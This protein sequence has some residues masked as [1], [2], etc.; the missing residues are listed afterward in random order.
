MTRRELWLWAAI[1]TFLQLGVL[2]YDAFATYRLKLKEGGGKVVYYAFPLTSTGTLALALG[3]LLCSYVI[4]SSTIEEVYRVERAEARLL[5]LQRKATVSDQSFD[6]YLI[7]PKDKSKFIRTS[8]RDS[9]DDDGRGRDET[10][11]T[12]NSSLA[13]EVITIFAVFISFCGFIIQFIGLRAMHWSASLAQLGVTLI[14]ILVRAWVRRGLAKL[15]YAQRLP[16][17]HEL[18]WLATRR[19][20]F[21]YSSDHTKDSR[22]VL[23]RV[24]DFLC[25]RSPPPPPVKTPLQ[26]PEFVFDLG[27]IANGQQG[28][29]QKPGSQRDITMSNGPEPSTKEV[30]NTAQSVM[31]VRKRLGSLTEWPGPASEKATSVASAIEIVMNTLFLS[32]EEELFWSM[33]TSSNEPVQF[34]L[35]RE[36][37]KWEADVAEIDAALSLW[38]FSVSEE[39]QKVTSKYQVQNDSTWLR[40]KTASR[41]Q[42]LQLLGPSTLSSR[43]DM[44]WWVGSGISRVLEVIK[45][46]F[47]DSKLEIEEVG[48]EAVVTVDSHRVVGSV[49]LAPTTP[50]QI[51]TLKSERYQTRQIAR[52]PI[53]DHQISEDLLSDL[54][55]PANESWSLA[56]IS[57]LPLDSLFAQHMFSAF[58]R[59][60]ANTA[61][62]ARV[63]G[64]ATVQLAD[65]GISH[66]SKAWKYFALQ[67]PRLS[68][69]VRHIQRTGLGSLEEIYMN[70]I[71]ALSFAN[72]IC[73]A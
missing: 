39:E 66:N 6:S 64:Q 18:D 37:G 42:S 43:R 51:N 48:D 20:H 65:K 23:R 5:W 71:P 32:T 59:A 62:V 40:N 69:M 3:M 4:E 41:K 12:D 29:V 45:V 68:E 50:E 10:L 2:V 26:A 53:S 11:D 63:N 9:R 54:P 13:P 19:E 21:W 17:G 67:N 44:R 34:K 58:M 14:M 49:Y 33:N 15:P 27:V 31:E 72:T 38:L 24:W 7:F 73:I 16:S 57:D 22:N 56:T 30:I 60:F 55:T 8:R 36:G 46:T 47:D 61:T 52:D 70:I 35:R 28:L 25:R 1:T